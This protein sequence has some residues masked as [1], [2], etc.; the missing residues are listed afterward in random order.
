MEQLDHDCSPDAP[1]ALYGSETMH[2][3]SK[4]MSHQVLSLLITL[5]RLHEADADGSLAIGYFLRS[6]ETLD[7]LLPVWGRL[8]SVVHDAESDWGHSFEAAR[9]WLKRA[10]LQ[11]RPCAID[12][13][14]ADRPVARATSMHGS[15]Q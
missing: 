9:L 12:K 7:E 2:A 4:L 1:V 13:D 6:A 5:A 10:R 11:R 15:P 8:S 14:G 3:R